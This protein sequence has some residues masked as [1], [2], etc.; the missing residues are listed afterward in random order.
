MASDVAHV[1][2]APAIGLQ[3]GRAAVDPRLREE[4][5]ALLR[6]TDLTYCFQC[7][8]CTAS[9]PTVDRMEFGPRRLM[10]MTHLGMADAVLRSKDLWYCVSCYSCAARCPQGIGVADVLSSL[11]SMSLSRGMAKDKEATFS[12]LFVDVLQRY[13]RMYEPE[14]MLRYFASQPDLGDILDMA[15][16]GLNMIR[17][18]KL[19]FAPQRVKGLDQVRA[20]VERFA[21][22]ESR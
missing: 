14:V 22:K 11:R 3:G 7:G 4:V 6:G 16:L 18:G 12:R 15:P 20:I 21:G 19:G 9:C 1:S 2:V 13:G 17:K 5:A 8:V 10:H